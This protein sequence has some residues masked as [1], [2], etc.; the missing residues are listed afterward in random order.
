M[1]EQCLKASY[2]PALIFYVLIVCHLIHPSSPSL[3]P[4]STML[5]FYKS[6]NELMGVSFTTD[7]GN[8]CTRYD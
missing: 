3:R 1:N 4:S 8:I 6:P 7:D 5:Q 2:F